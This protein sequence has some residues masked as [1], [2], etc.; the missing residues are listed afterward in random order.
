M[1]RPTLP[2]DFDQLP[3]LPD[4][5]DLDLMIPDEK[6]E[7]PPPPYTYWPSSLVDLSSALLQRALLQ[8]Q[9]P[10]LTPWE[11]MPSVMPSV[12]WEKMVPQL[13]LPGIPMVFH[14]NVNGWP[15]S[16][17][18]QQSASTGGEKTG[19]NDWRGIYNG[20]WWMKSDSTKK[21]QRGEISPQEEDEDSSAVSADGAL[22]VK[23][24]R[25]VD[26]EDVDVPVGEMNSFAYQIPKDTRKAHTDRMLVCFWIPI[27][28][29]VVSWGA[30]QS[31]PYLLIALRHCAQ[32]L[33]PNLPI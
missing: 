8:L 2:D 3:P 31:F 29:I 5:P 9:P 6:A 21:L 10:G 15:P 14:V 23:A 33:H 20:A 17:T 28:I 30:F 24:G 16:L 22:P 11:K 18:W 25:R 32:Y 26:Y 1:L 4:S 19:N 27:L 13:H 7:A 12:P